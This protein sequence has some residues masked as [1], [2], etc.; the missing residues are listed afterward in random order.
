MRAVSGHYAGKDGFVFECPQCK[1]KVAVAC[2][3]EQH[4]GNI[5]IEKPAR[6]RNLKPGK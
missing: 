3:D 4:L 5:D 2:I 1:R 6:R